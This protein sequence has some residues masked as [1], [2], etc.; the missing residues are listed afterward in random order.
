MLLSGGV[1]TIYSNFNYEYSYMEITKHLTKNNRS[2]LKMLEYDIKMA[3]F[4]EQETIHGSIKNPITL[5]Q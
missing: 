4:M 2:T 1:Y 5:V 3:G